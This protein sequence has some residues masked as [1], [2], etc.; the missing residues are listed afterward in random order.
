MPGL[1]HMLA[2]G[3][4]VEAI[5]HSG[6]SPSRAESKGGSDNNPMFWFTTGHFFTED[7]QIR[8]RETLIGKSLSNK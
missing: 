7:Q 6:F 5:L 2:V 8:L 4:S 3:S 1:E